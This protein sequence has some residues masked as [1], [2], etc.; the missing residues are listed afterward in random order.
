MTNTYKNST[1]EGS[2]A[3]GL[4]EPHQR[5]ARWVQGL[6]VPAEC[7]RVVMTVHRQPGMD[8]YGYHLEVSDPHTKELMAT[9]AEPARRALE[10][11]GLVSH[12]TLDIRAVLLELTD[13]DPF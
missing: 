8:A 12:V 5:P 4:C 11:V 3:H 1:G 6:T 7:F 13:P 9:V 2:G 10:S